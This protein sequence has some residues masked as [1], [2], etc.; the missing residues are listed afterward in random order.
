MDYGCNKLIKSYEDAGWNFD[1]SFLPEVQHN[2][3]VVSKANLKDYL[4]MYTGEYE[5]VSVSQLKAEILYSQ[6]VCETMPLEFKLRNEV[7]L[8]DLFV[9]F[10]SEIF[11]SNYWGFTRYESYMPDGWQAYRQSFEKLIPENERYWLVKEGKY[12]VR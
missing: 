3:R 9:D 10:D 8:P 1:F 7:L 4:A 11:Y 2:I 12:Y 5:K 6:S